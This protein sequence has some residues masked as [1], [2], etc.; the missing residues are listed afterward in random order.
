MTLYHNRGNTTFVGENPQYGDFFGLDDLFTENPRVVDGMTDIYK[1][2]IRE[3]GIDGFRM[4]TM[5]HVDDAFWQRF[6]PAIERYAK[7]R[8]IDDFYMF[9]EVAEDFDVKITSHYPTHDK[10]QGVLDFLFQVSAVDFAAKSLGTDSLRDFFLKDDWYT[11]RDSNAYNLPT[12][13]GNHDRG[14]IGMFIRNANPGATEAELLRRDRLA[15]ALMYFSRGNPVVYYGDEQGFTGKGGD[16]DARQDM[17][18]SQDLE[19]DNLGDDAG[20]ND[21]IGSDETPMDD[22][23]DR[24]HPL[25]KRIARLSRITQ[26]HAALRD[27][28]QQSRYSQSTPGVYAFSRINRKH[29]REYVV[30]LNNAESSASASI[31]TYV[32]NSRWTKVFGPGPERLDDGRR[33]DARRDPAGAVGRGLQ[34]EGAD[35]AQPLGPVRGARRAARWPRPPRGE[36]GPRPGPV[37]RGDVPGQGRQGRLEG[38]RDRRQRALPRVPR[39][40]RPQAGDAGQ[41]PRGRPRQ[42]APHAVERRPQRDDRAAGG[43]DHRPARGLEGP[44]RHDC[45]GVRGAGTLLRR[46]RLRA[47]GRQR[48][49]DGHRP[50]RLVAGVLGPRHVLARPAHRDADPLPRDART[51]RSSA[52][53]GP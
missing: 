8:G 37:R 14:R 10:V 15:H 24:A 33:Q 26:R 1:Y 3:F 40:V 12:F 20:Q 41:V 35:P 44:R 30:A 42:R 38:H 31:P 46:R 47:S 5:K 53:S 32:G 4:D 18:P 21:N 48:P 9:G 6:A 36:R 29:R 27:G 43:H 16:Q 25:Y 2:W 7:S 19:Y 34:G 17:F 13:L 49:V 22:N 11:D 45:R 51:G 39:R 52:T 28:A 50:R 23:F